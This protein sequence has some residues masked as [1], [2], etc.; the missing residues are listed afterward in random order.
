MSKIKALSGIIGQRETAVIAAVVDEITAKPMEQ[1]GLKLMPVKAYPQ[2]LIYVDQVSGFGGLLGEREFGAE[3]KVSTVSSATT[4]EYSPAAYQDSKRFTEK[5]LIALRRLG[6]IGDRGATGI[7]SGALDFMGRA[8]EDLKWKLINRLNKLAWDS[9]FTGIWTFNGVTKAN[10][11][12]PTAITPASTWSN[13]TSSTPMKDLLTILRTNPAIFKYK[14]KEII[15][16]PVTAVAFL[17][18]AEVRNVV[19]N[20]AFAVGD[21]NK[22]KD[23]LYP[24]LP[25]FVV[26]A[27]AW[28]D[29]VV[30]AGV[31]THSAA[32]YFIPNYGALLVPDF[33]GYM[34]PQLGEIQMTYNMNDPAS[35]VENPAM[36][37]YTFVDEQGL[38]HRKAPWVDVV[39]GFN[40]GPA[41]IRQNDVLIVQGA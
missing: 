7:T 1:L 27:D 25:P 38:Q 3:G 4:L 6:G 33:S 15:I 13:N 17:E 36:G 10:F 31:V 24:G 20:N 8:A 28:Q 41:V 30:T 9:L 2:H 23:I 35:T 14:I 21:L 37:V 5:D 40:G 32:T 19:I 34:Y 39:C 26:C 12:I 11:G 18:S 16:N 22:A 29:Q